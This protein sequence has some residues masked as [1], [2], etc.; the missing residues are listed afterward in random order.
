MSHETS[1]Q[2]SF[3]RSYATNTSSIGNPGGTLVSSAIG[4]GDADATWQHT[5][6]DGVTRQ[7][8]D[9]RRRERILTLEADIARR[10]LEQ[11]R[12]RENTLASQGREL[13]AASQSL[14][15]SLD[16]S[17]AAEQGL[18]QDSHALATHLR[19]AVDELNRSQEQAREMQR[20]L[21]YQ[22]QSISQLQTELSRADVA[23]ARYTEDVNASR[24][25]TTLARTAADLERS[26]RRRVEASIQAKGETINRLGSE[27]VMLR[28][29]AREAQTGRDE[30]AQELAGKNAHVDR[31][32]R[33]QLELE[34]RYVH[35]PDNNVGASCD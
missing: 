15:Q 17:Y 28:H 23:R 29:R 35:F 8:A 32:T 25:D 13:A 1:Y 5:R 19:N 11:S 9:E 18:R 12:L 21:Q 22:Q 26:Q 10:Q 30:L 34:E 4:S 20:D 3:R 16:E 33:V 7:L 2:S 24:R 27:S 31:L 14:R 6:T